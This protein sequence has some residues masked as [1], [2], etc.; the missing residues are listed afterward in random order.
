MKYC[1]VRKDVIGVFAV[2]A[3]LIPLQLL[4]ADEG[5]EDLHHQLT[6]KVVGVNAEAYRG[7]LLF[8]LVR[9][10][11][12]SMHEHLQ[13]RGVLKSEDQ[14]VPFKVLP[15]LKLAGEADDGQWARWYAVQDI[16]AVVMSEGDARLTVQLDSADAQGSAIMIDLPRSVLNESEAEA[17]QAYNELS[18]AQHCLQALEGEELRL[19]EE[20]RQRL[21]KELINTYPD[22]RYTREASYLLGKAY[23]LE[24]Q[25]KVNNDGPAG[26]Y[27]QCYPFLERAFKGQPEDPI[28]LDA[29]LTLAIAKAWSSDYAGA[30]EL[31]EIMTESHDLKTKAFGQRLKQEL[32]GFPGHREEQ[33]KE[34]Q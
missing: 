24:T 23:F 8:V 6:L 11:G 2:M 26:V 22:S 20:Y 30:A 15:L 13:L 9:G 4:A 3:C 28:T 32:K 1:I 18:V 14:Q 31:A 25:K 17:H 12:A 34:D 7:Q 5:E 10:K 21:L 33:L 29:I 19:D 16:N 27:K